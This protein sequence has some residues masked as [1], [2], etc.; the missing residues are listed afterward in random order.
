MNDVHKYKCTTVRTHICGSIGADVYVG[1][2]FSF[3]SKSVL[4]C[5]LGFGVVFFFL[6]SF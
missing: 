1:N 6:S 3:V 5:I 2:C 4:F